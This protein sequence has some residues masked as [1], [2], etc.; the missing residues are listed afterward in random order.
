VPFPTGFRKVPGFTFGGPVM[1]YFT[2]G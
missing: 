1:P 2:S